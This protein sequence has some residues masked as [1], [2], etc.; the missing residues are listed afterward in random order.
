MLSRG[1]LAVNS[2]VNQG[3]STSEQ[4][5]SHLRGSEREAWDGED[6]GRQVTH[7]MLNTAKLDL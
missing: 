7:E 1:G 4:L 3:V 2:D 6:M 5:G